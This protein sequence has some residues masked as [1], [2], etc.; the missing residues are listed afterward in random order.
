[1][2]LNCYMDE[3]GFRRAE[4]PLGLETLGSF[5]ED[6][7]QGSLDNCELLL[8]TLTEV[9]QGARPPFHS[10]GN[11]HDVSVEPGVVTIEN[12]WSDTLMPL[13]LSPMQYRQAI[14]EWRAFLRAN[15]PLYTLEQY[16]AAERKAEFRSEFVSGRIC[17]R[18]GSS[19]WHNVIMGSIVHALSCRL[20]KNPCETYPGDMRVLIGP[21][22]SCVYPDVTVTSDDPQFLD[23]R[24]D[25]LLNPLVIVE[26][27]SDSTEAYDRGA[28]FALYQRLDSLQEYL[29]VSQDKARVEKYLRQP[30]GQWLY[31]RTDDLEGEV[32]LGALGCRLPLSEVYARVQFAPSQEG[33]ERS[34]D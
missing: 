32:S 2:L 10:T 17:L 25:V 11:A 33:A 14:S 18:A 22:N 7:V 4:T 3:R 13:R 30:G 20:R 5:L 15:Q 34:K 19:R 21:V 29:L 16:L 23:H 6:D 26:V 8:E 24:S 28:K 1:M 12:I 27:L 31:S 9:E